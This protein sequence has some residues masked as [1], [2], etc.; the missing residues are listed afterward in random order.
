MGAAI[1]IE[2]R[3]YLSER[4]FAFIGPHCDRRIRR[5][6]GRSRS[7]G[8]PASDVAKLQRGCEPFV[9]SH[10]CGQPGESPVEHRWMPRKRPSNRLFLLSFFGSVSVHEKALAKRRM[11]YYAWCSSG[12]STQDVVDFDLKALSR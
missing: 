12:T 6:R 8:E 11:P 2:T 7:S 10:S 3:K 9:G 4:G 5:S 1:A